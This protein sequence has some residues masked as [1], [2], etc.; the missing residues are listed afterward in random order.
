M[1]LVNGKVLPTLKVRQR[2]AAAL[3]R[4]QC[5][6]RSVLQPSAAQPSV[7]AARR[8]QRPRGA[9]AGHLQLHPDARRAR[10]R[11]LHA[12]RSAG[13]EQRAALGA[14]RA[15]LRQH[16]QPLVG[17]DARDR[18]RRRRARDSGADTDG[19]AHDRADRRQR[20]PSIERSTSRS[21]SHRRSRWASTACRTGRRSRSRSQLGDTEVWRIV[22]NTDFSHPFHLHGYFF[23]VLDD[24]R[25]PEWK[26]TVNVPNKSELTIAVR[27]DERPGAWMYHCHILDHAEAGMMGHLVVSDPSAPITALPPVV[28]ASLMG[29]SGSTYSATSTRLPSGSRK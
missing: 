29:L 14:D 20:P 19:A 10:R 26:D 5:D 3:A 23:Q 4:H 28:H 25:V 11:R 6:A 22:N 17:A 9:L 8:R 1:L 18:N 21:R 15:R 12:G 7:H 13:N 24:S 27:F 16:V 2:Q